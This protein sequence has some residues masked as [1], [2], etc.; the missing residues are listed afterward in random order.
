VKIIERATFVAGKQTMLV[1]L[2]K[3]TKQ[4][5]VRVTVRDAG[6]LQ[7]SGYTGVGPEAEV[8]KCH[9]W[10]LKQA[11]EKGWAR[12]SRGSRHLKILPGVPEPFEP[13]AAAAPGPVS[14][15]LQRGRQATGRP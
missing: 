11:E 13:K 12:A 7:T 14:R 3:N 4:W 9:V 5:A 1:A 15:I 8:R 2:Q 10:T 6:K